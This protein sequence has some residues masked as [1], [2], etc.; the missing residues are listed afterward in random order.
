M[1]TFK[2]DESFCPIYYGCVIRNISV[3]YIILTEYKKL[4][5]IGKMCYSQVIF[6]SKLL[7]I[8][9]TAKKIIIALPISRVYDELLDHIKLR[10]CD[11]SNSP[12]FEFWTLPK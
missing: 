6:M 7:E 9:M 12:Y 10:W 2:V 4:H 8:V 11:K 1:D 5:V 3:S